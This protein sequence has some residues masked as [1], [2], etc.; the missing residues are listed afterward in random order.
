MKRFTIMACAGL[1][2]A[3]M[4]TPSFAAD[5]PPRPFYKGPAY[6]APVF[7]WTG[8]YVGINGGYGFG[9]SSWTGGGLTTG[10]F[11]T[12]GYLIG[13]TLGYNLQTG[14]W[15]YGVEGDLDYSANKGSHACGGGRCETTNNWL[16][17]ARGRVGYAFDRF[18]PYFTGGAAF[19]GVKMD[20]PGAG[21]KTETRFGWTLGGG[22]E[23]AFLNSWSAKLEYLYA[24]LGTAKCN[25]A[26]CGGGANV[27]FNTSMIRAGLNYR[28]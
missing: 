7:T 21:D 16:G 6:V 10:N 24:D 17:T 9:K 15:V 28:F 23:W 4:A 5:L 14:A 19:G 26:A 20:P 11:S 18:L 25:I 27:K 2:A 12:S 3:A 8:F 22:V 1:V 13:G